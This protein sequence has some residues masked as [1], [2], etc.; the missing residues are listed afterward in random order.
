MTDEGVPRREQTE[1]E[2][3][4][5]A[6]DGGNIVAAQFVLPGAPLDR[7]VAFFTN[8]LGFS[9][10]TI[11]PADDPRVVGL[12]GHGVRI[13]LDRDLAGDPGHLRLSCRQA[14][15]DTS[16]SILAPNGTRIEY[17]DA[18][19]PIVLPPLA[20]SFVLTKADD[21]SCFVE[22]RAGM[23]YRDLIPDRQNGRFIASHIRIPAG[24]AVPDY[25]HFHVVR[26]QMIFC[27]K[28]WVRVVYED[29]GPAFV[30]EAGD[31]VLQPPRIRHR[32]LECSPGL[33]V[34][35]IG[36]PAE[37]ETFGDLEMTLPTAEAKPQRL[38]G[39]QRFV[40]HI[41]SEAL[42]APWSHAGF[43]RRDLGIAD[44][45]DGLARVV[46]ARRSSDG[47]ASES[48]ADRSIHRG[49]LHFAF[50]LTGNAQLSGTPAGE[51]ELGA[52]DSVVVPPG[53]PMGWREPSSDFEI[54]DVRLP[55][56]ERAD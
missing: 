42:W 54:L 10:A 37:H 20:P 43:E 52:G 16:A 31:C 47:A 38:F 44:A 1:P 39:G 17:V 11:V 49:E 28:G 6:G 24:G 30:L 23:Q 5:D 12:V 34:V 4:A 21:S 26:F 56:E 29:Q 3:D 48:V 45:T 32:V 13:R 55:A 46:V 33:E 36:C 51:V 40:R 41:A 15:R 35:E 2:P 53:M 14:P 50:V 9:V 27:S 22:G 19:P 8:E 18:E 25:V 7:T